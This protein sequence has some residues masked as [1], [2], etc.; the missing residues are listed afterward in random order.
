MTPC[1]LSW[2]RHSSAP[3]RSF[4]E[5]SL[6]GDRGLNFD[7]VKHV[8]STNM[9]IVLFGDPLLSAR[10][11]RIRSVLFHHVQHISALLTLPMN[12]IVCCPHH[13]LPTMS[14]ASSP[15]AESLYCVLASNT[16]V[17]QRVTSSKIFKFYVSFV[18]V[19]FSQKNYNLTLACAG[20]CNWEKK[21]KL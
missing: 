9:P 4:G 12:E 7:N 21:K 1:R 13:E 5:D 17:P 8:I 15:T 3:V 2:I 14:I 19:F 10:W 11:N 18:D 6:V 20:R 16:C